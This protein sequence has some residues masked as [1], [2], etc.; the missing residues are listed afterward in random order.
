MIALIELPPA[1]TYLAI[2]CGALAASDM[3]TEDIRKLGWR[4]A[5][6]F[7]PIL[8]IVGAIA[9]FGALLYLR[10]IMTFVAWLAGLIK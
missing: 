1:C 5:L 9:S 6:Q 7:V 2:G 4:K 8:L 10:A 3:A